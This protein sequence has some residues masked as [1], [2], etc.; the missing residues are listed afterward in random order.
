MKQIQPLSFLYCTMYYHSP[1]VMNLRISV[2]KGNYKTL[3][4]AQIIFSF[5][6][7]TF[8]IQQSRR[9]SGFPWQWHPIH[10]TC[11]IYVTKCNRNCD[12]DIP[13]HFL[14]IHS[15]MHFFD[16]KSTVAIVFTHV[17]T[18][19]KGW[20]VFFKLELTCSQVLR[21]TSVDSYVAFERIKNFNVKID[22]NNCNF[23]GLLH[24]PF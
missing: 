22:W 2:E 17:P 3:S 19:H 9:C 21:S 15:T 13:V 20:T 11:S 16:H 10:K 8:V 4:E 23:V 5:V 24:H 14:I 12:H 6:Y 1:G 7:V 18:Y